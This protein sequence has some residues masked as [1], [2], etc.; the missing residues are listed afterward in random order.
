MLIDVLTRYLIVE[1]IKT[2]TAKEV[3][4]VFFESVVCKQGVPKILV[5][6]QCKEFINE[7]LK[8]VANL[9]QL[10]HITTI[11]KQMA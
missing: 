3:A 4:K 1:P 10:K 11:H 6:D 5:T 7:I 2:K 9:L 8:E